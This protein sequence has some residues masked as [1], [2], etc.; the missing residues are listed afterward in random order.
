MGK[1]FLNH[2][3]PVLL[4]PGMGPLV[5]EGDSQ[6]GQ[7]QDTQSLHTCPCA[8]GWALGG[9]GAKQA[10][11]HSCL[12]GGLG[13]E[14]GPPH[15]VRCPH[16]ASASGSSEL[17]MLSYSLPHPPGSCSLHALEGHQGMDWGTLPGRVICWLPFLAV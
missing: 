13:V 10:G 17:A 15:K 9:T 14:S 7:Q 6:R 4:W 11:L 1:G 8:E 3:R 16:L 5:C 12:E 2:P